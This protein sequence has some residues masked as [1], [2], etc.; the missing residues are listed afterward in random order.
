MPPPIHG[1]SLMGQYIYNSELINNTFDCH[2]LNLSIASSIEDVQKFGLKKLFRYIIL[3]LNV[4]YQI[5]LF[6]PNLV[7][8]TPNSCGK[9]FYKEFPIMILLKLMGRR[10]VAHY[11][12]KGV[13]SHSD[14]WLDNILYKMFFFHT[15]VILLSERLYSDISKYVKSEDYEVCPNGI[16]MIVDIPYNVK[17]V[18]NTHPP[19]LLFLSN[20][21]VAKGVWTL[22]DSLAELN[23]R[24][25]NFKCIIAGC[26]SAEISSEKLQDVIKD[27]KLSNKVSYYGPVYG[28]DKN[29]LLN[30]ADIF[31]F[32]SYNECFPLVLLEAMQFN[33]PC[34]TTSVGGI[35]DI[36]K[37]G[38]NG[39]ICKARNS[40][41][42]SISI[43]Q[44]LIDPQMRIKLGHTGREILEKKFELSHFYERLN[45]ILTLY[46]NS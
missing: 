43:E 23:D 35:L 9:P 39:L 16:P 36:V 18:N 13:L 12:N 7:Y 1:A 14:R 37:D 17:V 45:K 11:H 46:L 33:L 24:N 10:V 28:Q 15:K 22:I 2:Y 5:I 44:L 21:L 27:K 34:I 29:N 4:I 3:L 20:L 31:V 26:E 8:F 42:L 25:I 38:V 32:P 6:R 19:V 30:Q 40:K 41:S